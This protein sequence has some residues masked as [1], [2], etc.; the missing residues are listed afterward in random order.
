MLSVLQKSTDKKETF[1]LKYG[2]NTMTGINDWKPD[3]RIFTGIWGGAQGIKIF[4]VTGHVVNNLGYL[5]GVEVSDPNVRIVVEVT[6]FFYNHMFLLH[7]DKMQMILEV[8]CC[9]TKFYLQGNFNFQQ[10]KL[11]SL[12]VIN[13]NDSRFFLRWSNMLKNQSY[14]WCDSE[15]EKQGG[16]NRKTSSF[17]PF[18]RQRN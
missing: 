17:F 6:N 2:T 15:R 3:K 11:C 10:K 8:T 12:S 1:K 7:L 14:L 9:P 13:R 16:K 18:R 5:L 4:Y